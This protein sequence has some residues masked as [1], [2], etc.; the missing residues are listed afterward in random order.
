MLYKASNQLFEVWGLKGVGKKIDRLIF[1]QRRINL[2]SCFMPPLSVFAYGLLLPFFLA[3][4][5]NLLGIMSILNLYCLIKASTKS[6]H[7]FTLV[8]SNHIYQVR[9]R[10]LRL[11]W[12][13]WINFSSWTTSTILLQHALIWVIRHWVLVYLIYSGAFKKIWNDNIIN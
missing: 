1:Q 7:L 8:L 5:L 2:Y 4:K 11:S 12:K 10:S 9:I 3:C 6:F 13:K